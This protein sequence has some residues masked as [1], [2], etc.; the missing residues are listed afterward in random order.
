MSKKVEVKFNKKGGTD[1]R[2]SK[3]IFMVG[4]A[5]LSVLFAAGVSQAA[6]NG[7]EETD[8]KVR[9]CHMDHEGATQGNVIVVSENAVKAHIGHGDPSVF[10]AYEDGSCTIVRERR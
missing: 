8:A 7:Q 10:V 6:A 9:V 2:A 1:M 4:V 5:A 3:K